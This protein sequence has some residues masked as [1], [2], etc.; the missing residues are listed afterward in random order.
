MV[1]VAPRDELDEFRRTWQYHDP[2]MPEQ[3]DYAGHVACVVAVGYYH[4]G[5]VLYKLDGV[6]GVWHEQ[7]LRASAV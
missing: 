3:L 2:L 5:D 4:G 7:L 6:P 1:A